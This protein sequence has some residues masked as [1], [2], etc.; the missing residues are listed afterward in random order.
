M[1]LLESLHLTL[2]VRP[3]LLSE[4]QLR[5][6]DGK[7]AAIG[8]KLILIK[9]TPQALWQRCIWERRKN[10][11]ITK[12]GRKYGSTLQEI[13]HYYVDEQQ[14]MLELFEQSSMTKLLI[15]GDASPEVSAE[16]AYQFWVS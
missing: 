7:L 4:S 6:F 14:H 11:F 3:G 1:C 9:V 2:G 16:R 5:D 12:Y 15:D 8:C 13:H 10:G